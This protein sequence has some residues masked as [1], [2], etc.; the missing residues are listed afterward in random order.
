MRN[1]YIDRNGLPAMA[2][3]IIK[4]WHFR[5]AVRRRNV[6]MYKVLVRVDEKRRPDAKGEYLCAFDITEMAQKPLDKVHCCSLDGIA[7]EII[8]GPS[9]H[10]PDKSLT[11]WWGRRKVKATGESR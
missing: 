2:G 4:I 9:I 3:D 5:A 7:F 11:C 10:N 8:D 1:G 6:F